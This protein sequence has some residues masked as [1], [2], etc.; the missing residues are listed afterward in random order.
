MS[1]LTPVAPKAETRMDR[2]PLS[3]LD[4]LRQDLESF[5]DRPLWRTLRRTAGW[6]PS[7]DVFEKEGEMIVKADLPG[8]KKEDVQVSLDNGDLVIR[9]ERRFESKVEEKDYFRAER[10][11]G[12]FYRRFPLPFAPDPKL[13]AAK[14]V[15]GVLEVSLPIPPEAKPAAT[16]IDVA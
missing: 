7:L 2:P 5:W 11:H 4:E 9:G 3:L 14:F 8:V 13:V 1:V 6:M 10:E 15:D 12:E 16:K